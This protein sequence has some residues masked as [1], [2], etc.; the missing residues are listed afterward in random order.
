MGI[1]EYTGYKAFLRV[2]IKQFPKSGRGV[3]A[4]LAEHLKL[5]ATVVSQILSRDRHFTPDQAVEVAA[6]FGLDERATD[7]FIMLVHLARAESKKLKSYYEQKLEKLRLEAQNLRNIVKGR[8]ELSDADKARF[9]SNWYYA[10]VFHLSAIKGYQTVEAI[11]EYYGLS[12]AK[13]GEV[14]SY[15]LE[16]GMLVEND[17]ELGPG[18]KST[19]VSDKSEFLNNHRRNWRDKAREK[20][21]NPGENDIFMSG[22]VSMGKKDAEIF[23]AELL[24]LIKRFSKMVEPSPSE[25]LQCLNIDWFEF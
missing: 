16:C 15:L 14:V 21:T 19:H 1:Y 6:F 2:L 8:D 7:Y 18:L 5:P 12:R 9:Y 3:S 11:A 13:I 17:G 24:E 25:K 23:R 10:A 20:F 4:R 22:P